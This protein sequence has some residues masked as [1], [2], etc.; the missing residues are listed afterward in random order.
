MPFFMKKGKSKEPVFGD[1]FRNFS[2]STNNIQARITKTFTQ[3]IQSEK[4][5]LATQYG[6]IAGLGEM[7]SEVSNALIHRGVLVDH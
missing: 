6:A 3:A 4:A 2:T 5:A 7:G 1:F